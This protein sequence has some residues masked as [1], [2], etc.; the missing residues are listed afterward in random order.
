VIRRVE[1][2]PQPLRQLGLARRAASL[3]PVEETRDPDLALQYSN[4]F[5]TVEIT[6]DALDRYIEMYGDI[7]LPIRRDAET[8]D[9]RTW[10]NKNKVKVIYDREMHLREI[11]SR[12]RE[13]LHVRVNFPNVVGAGERGAA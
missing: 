6:Y 5:V 1:R 11:T 2:E 7:P 3:V 9:K 4:G 8:G 10:D 13:G 12:T